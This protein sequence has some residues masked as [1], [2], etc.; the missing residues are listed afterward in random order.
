[1]E[2][3]YNRR[4]LKFTAATLLH[5]AEVNVTSPAWGAYPLFAVWSNSPGDGYS[6]A[7]T[8]NLDG[9]EYCNIQGAATVSGAV[10][11]PSTWAM[12]LLGFAGLGY[13]G[14]RQAKTSVTVLAA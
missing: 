5:P 6:A 7:F 4:R 11:E 9:V 3:H 8:G 12:L 10:P 2:I 1:M 13:A 14:Y